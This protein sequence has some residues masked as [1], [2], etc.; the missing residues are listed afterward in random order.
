MMN[1]LV[2][3]TLVGACTLDMPD[4]QIMLRSHIVE[5]H[6][7]VGH[8]L[9]IVPFQAI[10]PVPLPL[11]P[12]RVVGVNRRS[13]SDHVNETTTAHETNLTRSRKSER[14]DWKIYDA[15]MIIQIY[16]DRTYIDTQA[17][18]CNHGSTRKRSLDSFTLMQ[19]GG[20][21]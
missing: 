15:G 16:P 4:T 1:A 20:R 14:G 5:G 13:N 9:Y 21:R 6:R 3:F 8:V 11:P 7:A 18:I 2:D 12:G 19:I 10:R 17:H